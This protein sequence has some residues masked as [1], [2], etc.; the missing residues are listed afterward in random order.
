MLF[1]SWEFF[2]VESQAVENQAI[3]KQDCHKFKVDK[4]NCNVLKILDLGRFPKL[5]QKF[6]GSSR[7]VS[8]C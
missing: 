8:I 7:T 6:Q 4:D 5:S 2:S 1:T 3:E